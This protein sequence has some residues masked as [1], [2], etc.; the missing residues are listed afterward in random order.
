MAANIVCATGTAPWLDP[1][2]VDASSP[3][4]VWFQAQV[5]NDGDEPGD[6][7]TLY[8]TAT[9]ANSTT[10]VN[11]YFS[12]VTVGVGETKQI[13][14]RIEGSRLAGAHTPVWVQL[15]DASGDQLGGAQLTI[16]P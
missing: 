1:D 8:Y 6:I 12:S 11:E 2:N 16:N 10:L 7:S 9:D 14:A 13:G 15:Y 4:D 5:T 3:G